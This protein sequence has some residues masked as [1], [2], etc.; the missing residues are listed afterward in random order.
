MQ[1]TNTATR[2]VAR[3]IRR[4]PRLSTISTGT[5]TTNVAHFPVLLA[6]LLPLAGGLARPPT[7]SLLAGPRPF[8][9]RVRTCYTPNIIF[10]DIG[11]SVHENVV[12]FCKFATILQWDLKRLW[13]YLSF[14][15]CYR[16]IAG[17]TRTTPDA[18]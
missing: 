17:P 13:S 7:S 4:V 5:V 8:W 2:A 10:Q 3:Q 18:G 14:N 12:P 16:H 9:R 6:Q 11:V 15:T 1:A